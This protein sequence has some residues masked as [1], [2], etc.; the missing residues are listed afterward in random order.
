LAIIT[1]AFSDTFMFSLDSF[2]S[3]FI[4]SAAFLSNCFIDSMIA[5]LFILSS[6]TFSAAVE[7]SLPMPLSSFT[8]SELAI[9]FFNFDILSH[10]PDN[11]ILL[12]L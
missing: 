1:A 9:A 3:F 8:R 2:S 6:E 4:L 10:L 12:Y 5:F 7:I 11:L